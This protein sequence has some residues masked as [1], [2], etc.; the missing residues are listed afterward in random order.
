VIDPE[1]VGVLIAEA[2][3]RPEAGL[4]SGRLRNPDG[5]FQPTCRRFPTVGNMV[6]ARGSAISRLLRRGGDADE[7]YTL[8][9]YHETIEVPAVAAT[10]VLIRRELFIRAGG[11]DGRY[12][13][14]MEDTDLSLRLS[15]LDCV[16]LFVPGSGGV[17]HWGRGSRAGRL[18]R[19]RRHHMSVWRYFLKHFPNGFSVFL[20]PLLLTLNFLVLM[21]LPHRHPGTD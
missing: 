21:M 10:M 5:S 16:N 8:P 13:M 3:R 4:V 11:F 19:L 7:R 6:F 14:Y 20:L 12:F 1:S 18:T 2:Q 17:H 15:R 9:D